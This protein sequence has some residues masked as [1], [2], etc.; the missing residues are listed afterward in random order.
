M[1]YK[2]LEITDEEKEALEAYSGIGHITINSLLDEGIT[3]EEAYLNEPGISYQT[4]MT[5]DQLQKDI[6]MILYI[7]QAMIKQSLSRNMATSIQ[8]YRGTTEKFSMGKQQ[9]FLSTTTDYQMANGY[10]SNNWTNQTPTVITYKI[11][12]TVPFFDM[13]QLV[14]NNE[15]EYLLPPFLEVTENY[16]R[17]DGKKCYMTCSVKEA[18][19]PNEETI[20]TISEQTLITAY[21]DYIRYCEQ[22]KT[23][24]DKIDRLQRLQQAYRYQD[25][26]DRCAVSSAIDTL[27]TEKGLHEQYFKEA[28]HRFIAEKA[29]V[30]RVLQQEFSKIKRQVTKQYQDE[31]ASYQQQQQKMAER[32]RLEKQFQNKVVSVTMPLVQLEELITSVMEMGRLYEIPLPTLPSIPTVQPIIS[33]FQ[34]VAS[35]LSDE[36]V[37]HYSQLLDQ[38]KLEEIETCSLEVKRRVGGQIY[39]HMSNH[40]KQNMLDQCDHQLQLVDES[41]VRWKKIRGQLTR[42]PYISQQEQLQ[43]TRQQIQEQPF[44]PT[45]IEQL[46]QHPNHEQQAYWSNLEQFCRQNE[47]PLGFMEEI[48]YPE[49]TV[50]RELIELKQAISESLERPCSIQPEYSSTKGSR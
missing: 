26:E 31:V 22:I 5:K 14:E 7:Y 24:D 34:N 42:K 49:L 46:K 27:L 12:R 43:Q 36:A 10:F 48:E 4:Y 21:Q 47:I 25:Y 1:E 35:K 17:N 32:K 3:F 30:H 19:F 20:P 39:Q 8:V 40:Q 16:R 2:S 38:I 28:K 29:K 45:T 18:A 13:S 33:F 11:D 6:F 23:T 15:K 41:G 50:F 37:G 9:T 44:I